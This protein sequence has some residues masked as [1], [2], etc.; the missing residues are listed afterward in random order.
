MTSKT[1]LAKHQFELVEN[2]NLLR[3]ISFGVQGRN[4]NIIIIEKDKNIKDI[5]E[6]DV[7]DKLVEIPKETTEKRQCRCCPS[8]CC[9]KCTIM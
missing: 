6:Q 5:D 9:A 4:P 2:C 8:T 3:D 1:I 7:G